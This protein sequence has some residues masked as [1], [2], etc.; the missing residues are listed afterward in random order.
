V[1]AAL[2]LALLLAATPAAAKTAREYP[3]A[4]DPVWTALVRFLRVDENLKVVEKDADSGYILFELSEGKRTFS[5]AAEVM[6]LER[7]TRVVIRIG[8]RPA[9]MEAG[10]LDRFGDKLHDELG[11]PPPAPSPPPKPAAPP[12]PAEDKKP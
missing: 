1:K 6:K 2:A 4:Y 12:P 3:Y 9:Y 11:E 5:D 7:A 8:E 10:L